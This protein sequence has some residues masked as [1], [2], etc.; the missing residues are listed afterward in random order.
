MASS[1]S[2]SSQR[3]PCIVSVRLRMFL[4]FCVAQRLGCWRLCAFY[5]PPSLLSLQGSRR[6]SL[7]VCFSIELFVQCDGCLIWGLVWQ[8][9]L[10]AGLWVGQ[11]Y[12]VFLRP[13]FGLLV[14]VARSLSTQPPFA[15]QALTYESAYYRSPPSTSPLKGVVPTFPKADPFSLVP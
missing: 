3:L 4:W 8:A 9:G 2:S 1:G 12:G 7:I 6:L 10:V 13:G 5:F 11:A 15:T 14:S